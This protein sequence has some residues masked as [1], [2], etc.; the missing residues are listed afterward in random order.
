MAKEHHAILD[1]EFN[2]TPDE[3]SVSIRF[4][5]EAN[6]NKFFDEW[7]EEISNELGEAEL[8]Y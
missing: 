2:E 1:A 6:L 3:A 7:E 5:S 4:T 8:P